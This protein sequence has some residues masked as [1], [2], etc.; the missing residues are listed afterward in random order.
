LVE[1]PADIVTVFGE[2]GVV[3]TRTDVNPGQDPVVDGRREVITRGGNVGNQTEARR[4]SGRRIVRHL[5]RSERGG[6]GQADKAKRND[7]GEHDESG[8]GNSTEREL[9]DEDEEEGLRERWLLSDECIGEYR[10]WSI[11]LESAGDVFILFH[12]LIIQG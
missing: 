5:T 1:Y 12:V 8:C 7:F 10:E 2:N 6:G 11:E 9:R 4:E 3:E